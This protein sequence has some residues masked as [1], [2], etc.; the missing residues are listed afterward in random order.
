MHNL[1]IVLIETDYLII[2]KISQVTNHLFVFKSW[3]AAISKIKEHNYDLLLINFDIAHHNSRCLHQLIA[4]FEIA[5]KVVLIFETPK[6]EAMCIKKHINK[7]MSF[8]NI[9]RLIISFATHLNESKVV[10][11]LNEL[12][13]PSHLR[14]YLYL[15]EAINMVIND[16]RQLLTKEIYPSIAKDNH[17]TVCAVERAI[18][19]AIELGWSRGDIN[20]MDSLFSNLLNYDQD[21]PTNAQYI[22][23]IAND[24]IKER[25]FD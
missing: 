5:N 20:K 14:G 24:V 2:S 11:S 19:N 16:E 23:C 3:Q 6:I 1:Q 12:G 4:P 8:E 7:Q 13:I 17:T 21:R 9:N 15:K 22:F 25:H 10:A 18:R